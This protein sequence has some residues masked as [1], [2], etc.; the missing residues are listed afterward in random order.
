MAYLTDNM[1]SN[2]DS[3]VTTNLTTAG[4]R[5]TS[6]VGTTKATGA[7][8]GIVSKHTSGDITYTIIEDGTVTES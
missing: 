8:S 2:Y 1:G 3:L 6:G 7:G 4:F 5:P